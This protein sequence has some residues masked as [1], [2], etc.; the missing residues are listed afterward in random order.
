[1]SELN[2]D[3]QDRTLSVPIC[4]NCDVC[5]CFKTIQQSRP[6]IPNSGYIENTYN[7]LQIYVNEC[8]LHINKDII[9]QTATFKNV[10]IEVILNSYAHVLG[11]ISFCMD[12]AKIFNIDSQICVNQHGKIIP[13]GSFLS[14]F[15]NIA[16]SYADL[17]LWIYNKE[18]YLPMNMFITS[19]QIHMEFLKMM[20]YTFP[21]P[22]PSS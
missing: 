12:Q 14:I 22:P 16:K 18:D 21:P 17:Y 20:R 2:S 8:V 5:E 19:L 1:M 4:Y 3:H 9:S 15:F 6:D 13:L 10:K 7:W 11:S